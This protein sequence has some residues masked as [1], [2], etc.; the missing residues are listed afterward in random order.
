MREI[1]RKFLAAITFPLFLVG[2]FFVGIAVL[3][4]KA[5]IPML[6]YLFSIPTVLMLPYIYF[7]EDTGP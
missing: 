7:S 2:A 5:R 6:P 4:K 3:L 1:E